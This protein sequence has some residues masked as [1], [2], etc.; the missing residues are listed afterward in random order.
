MALTDLYQLT[1]VMSYGGETLENVFFAEKADPASVAGTFI[2]GFVADI[3]PKM[4][5]LVSNLVAF[6]AI[7]CINLGDP[8]DWD[9]E[10][11]TGTGG[12]GAGEML[13]IFNA[14]SYTFKPINRAI[15]AGG[16]RF[17]GIPEAVQGNGLIND[18][19]YLSDMETMRLALDS[20]V[21]SSPDDFNFV[22]IKRVLYDVP[23][24]DPVRQA[25]RLPIEGDP[26]VVSNFQVVLTSPKISHQTSRGNRR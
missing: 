15:K 7:R 14:I 11:L 4:R 13:P 1:V 9:E 6:N 22:V 8:E 24:T 19:G 5:L 21:G 3:L 10:P 18:S 26:L 16:K 23:D 12:A 20:Q 25:Y 2:A 17:S